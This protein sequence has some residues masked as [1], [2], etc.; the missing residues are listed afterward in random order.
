MCRVWFDENDIEGW[1]YPSVQ[2]S[3]DFNIAI[4]PDA[5]HKKLVIE[6]LRIVQMVD[7]EEAKNIR[8]IPDKSLPIFN[9]MKMF[10]QSDFKGEIKEGKI[11]WHPSNDLF[12]DF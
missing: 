1:L 9:L 2:S 6:D 8:K 12:G 3:S 11:I 4:K 10:I 5:A 7:K